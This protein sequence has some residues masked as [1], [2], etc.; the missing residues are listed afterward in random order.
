[1]KAVYDRLEEDRHAVLLVEETNRE[2]IVDKERL[3]E[4][5]KVHDWF[6]VTL[7]GDKIISITRDP[8]AAAAQ[9]EK[10]K[11]KRRNLKRNSRGSRFKRK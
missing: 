10:V 4:G 9:L 3:P 5:S 1:M 8:E 2:Y 11:S 6:E 7:Q